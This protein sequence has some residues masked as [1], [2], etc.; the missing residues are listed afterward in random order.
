MAVTVDLAPWMPLIRKIRIF[1]Y[2]TD[3]ELTRMLAL[4]DMLRFQAGEKLFSQGDDSLAVYALIEGQV[5]LSFRKDSGTRVSVG[6]VS[7]GEVFGEAGVFMTVK[8]TADALVAADSTLL[9]ID[10]GNMMAF[11][12]QHPV[13][14]N[15]LLMLMIYGLLSK[16]R[17]ANQMLPLE[18]PGVIEMDSIDPLF[19]DFMNET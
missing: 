12:K 8:R 15:K 10:R 16:L 7:A 3:G 5:D 9:K 13:G 2:L 1:S 11:I 19:Q 17:E 18:N 6:A 4:S 14:G